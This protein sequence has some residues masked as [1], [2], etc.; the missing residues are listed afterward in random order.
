MVLG[1][2]YMSH[3]A[4]AVFDVCLSWDVCS[5]APRCAVG[6]CQRRKAQ[7]LDAGKAGLPRACIPNWPAEACMRALRA[8]GSMRCDQ[9]STAFSPDCCLFPVRHPRTAAKHQTPI[10]LALIVVSELNDTITNIDMGE[11][12]VFYCGSESE[13]Q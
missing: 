9:A 2:L 4:H 7:V 11:R 12:A 10:N 13:P 3:Y 6:T 5:H 8:A 1:V